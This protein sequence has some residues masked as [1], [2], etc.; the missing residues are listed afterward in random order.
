MWRLT[1]AF[2]L[3]ALGC[4]N[5]PAAAWVGTYSVAI[6]ETQTPCSGG[7]SAEA[8]R[9]VF[10]WDVE[11]SG[12]GLRFPFSMCPLELTIETSTRARIV[13]ASCRV[14]IDGSSGTLEV[15]SGTLER[16]AEGMTG[17]MNLR[18]SLDDGRCAVSVS[19]VV[20]TRL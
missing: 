3:L 7:A 6:D 1:F 12:S 17:T 16:D 9:Q 18:L 13:H 20:A 15:I 8:P 19:D 11:R 5:D 2:A 10:T 14:V 4:A